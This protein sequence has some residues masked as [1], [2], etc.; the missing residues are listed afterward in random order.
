MREAHAISDLL[1]EDRAY[2]PLTVW[3]YVQCK[4][5]Q[6]LVE[7]LALIDIQQCQYIP[8]CHEYHSWH[9]GTLILDGLIQQRVALLG[10]FNHH[11]QQHQLVERFFNM[12]MTKSGLRYFLA[13]HHTYT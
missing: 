1:Y 12:N 2:L 7:Q 3:V 9:W 10:L 13:L 8:Q 5:L 11:R 4:V 6:P